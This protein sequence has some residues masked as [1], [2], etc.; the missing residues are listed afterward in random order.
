MKISRIVPPKYRVGRNVLNE[1]ELRQLLLEIAK[2]DKPSGIIIKDT[3]GN[4]A[5]A[6]KDGSLSCS[7]Y[8]LDINSHITL[9]VLRIKREKA[10]LNSMD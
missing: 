9:Q 2:G 6:E 1:Y 3:K 10:A 4:Y 8:G 7:L 5:T